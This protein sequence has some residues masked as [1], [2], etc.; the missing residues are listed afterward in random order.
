MKKKLNVALIGY[1]FM[2][3]THSNAFRKVGNFFDLD[4]E[5]VMKVVCA[6]DEAKVKAFASKWGWESSECDW[7]NIVNRPDIDLIDIGSPN[8]THAEIAIAAAKA[9][10]MIMCEKP[11]SMDAEEGLKMVK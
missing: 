4:Y 11:L 10:K 5:P 3:R 9:G 7:R 6:R 1:G 8:N 2:G